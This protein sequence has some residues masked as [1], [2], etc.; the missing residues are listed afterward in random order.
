MRRAKRPFRFQGGKQM[1]RKMIRKIDSMKAK[2]AAEAGMILAMIMMAF[3]MNVFAAGE[4]V[5]AGI[6]SLEGLLANIVTG[7]SDHHHPVGH[8]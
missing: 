8:F 5:V 7:P 3:P 1:I 4:E 6:N 2:T